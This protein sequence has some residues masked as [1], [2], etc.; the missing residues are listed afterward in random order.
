[1]TLTSCFI[2]EQWIMESRNLIVRLRGQVDTDKA[3]LINAHYDSVPTAPGVTDN[4]MG[5]TVALELVRYF[6]QHP[7]RHSIIFLINNAEEGGLG[8]TLYLDFLIKVLMAGIILLCSWCK[9]IH[10]ASLVSHCKDVYQS[11]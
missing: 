4:G 6:I 5:V 11:R 9:A 7:P 8:K 3:V 2:D 1:M 10:K